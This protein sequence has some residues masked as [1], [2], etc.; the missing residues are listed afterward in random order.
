MMLEEL[1]ILG[2]HPQVF[3]LH[4]GRLE[5]LAHEL[6]TG[7]F[8]APLKRVHVIFSELVDQALCI[9]VVLFLMGL[10]TEHLRLIS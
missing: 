10:S 9:V 1:D 6:D 5:A 8:F 4:Q 2:R 3:L 7:L